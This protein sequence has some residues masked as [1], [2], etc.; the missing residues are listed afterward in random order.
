MSYFYLIN[1]YLTTM[2]KAFLLFVSMIMACLGNF[3]AFSQ[4]GTKA[5]VK[6]QQK[7]VASKTTSTKTDL[8][9]G[10]ELL[11]KADCLS[12]HQE[13]VKVVGPSY[14]SVA[15]KYASTEANINLL[16]DKIIKGGGGTWGPVPMPPHPILPA[17]DAKKMVKYIL[18]LKAR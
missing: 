7:P 18:S 3:H 1:D 13:Q 16:T 11:S 15:E 5:P 10:K 9:K 14:V 2:K 8:L 6:S 12:C 4:N 17:T